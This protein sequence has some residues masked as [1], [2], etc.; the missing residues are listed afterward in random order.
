MPGLSV[1][2]PNSSEHPSH[3]QQPVAQAAFLFYPQPFAASS[4]LKGCYGQWNEKHALKGE[5]S[6]YIP[7]FV[8]VLVFIVLRN[9]AQPFVVVQEIAMIAVTRDDFRMPALHLQEAPGSDHQHPRHL[10]REERSGAERGAARGSSGSPGTELLR[11]PKL[12]P[13]APHGSR[14]LLSAEPSALPRPAAPPAQPGGAGNSIS[15]NNNNN[16]NNKTGHRGRAETSQG[17]AARRSRTAA[18][19]PAG[20]ASA[21]S[22]KFGCQGGEEAPTSGQCRRPG[23]PAPCDAGP[24]AAAAAGAAMLCG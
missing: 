17:T 8:P 20:A 12:G 15:N 18:K 11:G 19:P 1:Q 6:T 13:L 4:S 23:L 3:R 10:Q 5:R 21:A 7:E 9:G 2:L 14:Q 22:A 24:P 16:N